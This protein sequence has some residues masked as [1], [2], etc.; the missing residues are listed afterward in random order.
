MK[1]KNLY[2]MSALA[3][4]LYWSLDAYANVLLYQSAFRDELLLRTAH[5][6]GMVKILITLLIAGLGLAPLWLFRVKEIV[7]PRTDPL[8]ALQGLSEILFSSLSTKIN[9][10]KSLEKLENLFSLHSCLLFT[11]HKETLMLYNE[12]DF[13]KHAFRTKEIFPFRTNTSASVVETVASTCFVEKRS[14]S[15]DRITFDGETYTLVSFMLKEDKSEK[16]IGNVMLVCQGSLNHLPYHATIERFAQMLSF[17]L[18]LQMKKEN[19]EQL[20]I[21][22]SHENHHYDKTLNIMTHIKFLEHI[23]YEF[24][25]HKRYHTEATLMI[26]EIDMLKNLSTVFPAELITGLKKDF[27][28]MIRKNIRDVDIFGKWNNEQFALLLPNVDFRAAQ[29]MAK[30]LQVLL[31]E[32]KF[33]R[34]GKLSCSFGITSVSPKDTLGTFRT[35]SESALALASSRSNG[36]VEVKLLV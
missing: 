26:F 36:S 32:H 4:L 29:S 12:N 24:N 22:T 15:L 20:N 35:R 25:R 14:Y 9:V 11:Y 23:E 7:A 30:K 27:I 31:H 18:L 13:I 28:A 6:H 17:V 3:V 16:A 10:A 33:T 34:M 8:D 2:L 5:S 21:Q 19:L 1:K